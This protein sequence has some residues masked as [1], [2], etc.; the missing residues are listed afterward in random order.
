MCNF[1]INNSYRGRVRVHG[2]IKIYFLKFV[3]KLIH[4]TIHI[5]MQ[6][7]ARCSILSRF[8]SSC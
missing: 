7:T 5:S 3:A 4:V 2:D 8:L 1:M 6:M